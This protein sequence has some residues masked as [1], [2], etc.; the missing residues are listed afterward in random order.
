MTT[1]TFDNIKETLLKVVS[2]KN[3]TDNIYNFL[4]VFSQIALNIMH[5][6]FSLESIKKITLPDGN[7]AF[8]NSGADDVFAILKE[9]GETLKNTLSLIKHDMEHVSRIQK[10]GAPEIDRERILQALQTVREKTDLD[11]FSVDG[12]YYKVTNF[13]DMLDEQNRVLSKEMGIS[14]FLDSAPID[15]TLAIPTPAGG[16]PIILGKAPI[17]M[18][19]P[20][21]NGIIEIL[22][23]LIATNTLPLPGFV[24]T[25][26]GFAQGTLDV[27]RGRWKYGV[28]S[29]LG[30]MSREMYFVTLVLKLI[31]DVWTLIE[32]RLSHQL[33]MQIFMSGKSMIIGFYL[34]MF[35][36]FAPDLIRK[37]FDVMLKPVNDLYERLNAKMEEFETQANQVANP[38]GMIVRFPR[39]AVDKMIT[40]DDIQSL[41]TILSI[42]EV[43]CSNEVQ[44]IV[45]SSRVLPPLRFLF[46][47]MNIPI[48][49]QA[50][51]ERCKGLS[52]ET[53]SA[54]LVNMFEPQVSVVPGGPTDLET[55]KEEVISEASDIEAASPIINQM[56]EEVKEHE[57]SLE[58]KDNLK[59]PSLGNITSSLTNVAK[60]A[61]ASK[62]LPTSTN[63][64]KGM[65]LGKLKEQAGIPKDLKIPTS[66]ENAKSMAKES[67]IGKLK[68]SAG[69]PKDLKIPTSVENAKKIAATT[70]QKKVDES[71]KK[72]IGSLL[73]EK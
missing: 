45:R 21:I 18:F 1:A 53:I 40:L 28:L 36:I 6:D 12:L 31:R 70:V 14:K 39:I 48:S 67:A 7:L 54:T 41:Q 66:I 58:P 13:L 69:I 35:S 46:E 37:Q 62:G 61:L 50:V 8:D 56:E 19:P 51:Q 17:R 2:E 57:E 25:I 5:N 32:P 73:G 38:E 33:R 22:R 15:P 71:A 20:L 42:P 72:A 43:A 52:D 3:G 26:L 68:E 44:S 29:V 55:R 11:Y 10:G 63:N 60:G 4:H 59:V 24:D 47:M 30:T 16:A 49:D 23:V 27:A 65:A 64:L 34:R 9:N